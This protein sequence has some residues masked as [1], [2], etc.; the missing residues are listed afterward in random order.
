MPVLTTEERTARKNAQLARIAVKGSP[1]YPI[2]YAQ[3]PDQIRKAREQKA[4]RDAARQAQA[5]I[6]SLHV[7]DANAAVNIFNGVNL[8]S[9]EG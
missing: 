5:A 1:E 7:Q 2:L 4:V 6:Q 8:T 3:Q 9:G